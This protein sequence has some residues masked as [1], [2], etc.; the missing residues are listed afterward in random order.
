[1]GQLRLLDILLEFRTVSEFYHGSTDTSFSGKRGIHIGSKLAA[2]QALE[3]RIGVPAEGEWDGTREY[4]KTYLAGTKS[5]KRREIERGYYLTTGFN[6]FKVPEEDYLPAER[7]EKAKYSDGS[8]I[9]MDS[10]PNV[11][12][13]KIVGPM[14]NTQQ[15]PKTDTAANSLILRQLKLG[16][17]KNGYFYENE[18]EDSGSISAVVPNGSWLKIV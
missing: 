7:E 15:T 17:A 1:M 12:R 5:L 3:A 4:G 13:V 10:K 8:E 16:R 6:A 2:T 14:N 9:P 11:F 18:G